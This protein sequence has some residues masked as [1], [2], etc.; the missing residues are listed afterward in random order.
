MKIGKNK[1]NTATFEVKQAKDLNKIKI[2]RG[3][4][5]SNMNSFSQLNQYLKAPEQQKYNKIIKHG[6][7]A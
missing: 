5:S 2:K 6:R 3:S 7:N 4:G 1:I